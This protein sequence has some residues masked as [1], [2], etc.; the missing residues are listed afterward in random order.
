M[1][2]EEVVVRRKWMTREHFLD[3]VGATNLIP[4]P[5][6][7]EMAIHV[8]L[9]RAGLLG[10]L[11]AGWCFI[12]P[13]VVITAAIAWVYVEYGELP[14]VAPLLAGIKPAVL[15][16]VAAAAWRL[17][18]KA[19]KT[20]RLLA[21]GAIAAALSL[22]QY[23]TNASDVLVLLAVAF[24]GFIWLS[25]LRDKNGK[26]ARTAVLFGAAS[27]IPKSARAASTSIASVASGAT[28]AWAV[29]PTTW[30]L[31]LS[32]LKIGAILYG[33]GYVLVAYLRSELVGHYSFTEQQ[34]LDAVAIGQFTPGPVL[35]TATFVGYV[36]AGWPGAIA[37]TLG[38]FLPGFVA[39]AA[40][41]RLIPRLRKVAWTARFLDAINAASV[42]LLIAVSLRLT[43]GV[44]V[45]WQTA[46]PMAWP[47][48]LIA[49][50]AAV[51]SLRWNVSP[52]WLVL[53]GAVVGWAIAVA[54]G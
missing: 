14:A 31:G 15:V 10:L 25:I 22:A 34:L 45:D 17:A 6:S 41:H 24:A 48:W 11:V 35:S 38:I 32:F 27:L 29:G 30:S 33:S 40:V 16:V 46:R 19:L 13:A 53:G 39:V 26:A 3:L 8:G 2:E 37:A 51:C 44:L 21:I 4:G 9:H 23:Y 47:N 28:S 49:A 42:G 5:N 36:I 20:S 12:L 7:T 1:M 18:G 43:D 52:A 50:V 54:V